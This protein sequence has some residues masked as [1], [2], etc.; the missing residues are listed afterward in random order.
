MEYMKS[1]TILNNGVK[2]PL[3]GLGT[4]MIENEEKLINAVKGALGMGYRHIDTASF[5]NNEEQIGIAIKE[6][7]VPREDIFLVSKIWNSDQGYE[8]QILERLQQWR[9]VQAEGLKQAAEKNANNPP[10]P[11]RK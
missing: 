10:D 2:M 11:A 9:K 4:Y 7:G 1:Y 5:Y 8:K 6:S 3:L